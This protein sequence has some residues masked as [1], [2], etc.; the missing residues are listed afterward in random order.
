MSEKGQDPGHK[1]D[2]DV[3]TEQEKKLARPPLYKVL[4]HNDDYTTMEFVVMVLQSIFGKPQAEAV[5]I[6]LHVHR[7]GIGIAGVYTYEIAETKVAQTHALAEKHDYPLKCT[8][9]EA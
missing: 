5:Q 8:V 2:L 1:G 9:E 3:V 6:M 4:L 7:K